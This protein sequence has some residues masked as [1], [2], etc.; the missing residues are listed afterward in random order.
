MMPL[1]GYRMRW[2]ISSSAF[3]RSSSTGTLPAR[4]PLFFEVVVESR[5]EPRE[6]TFFRR[7]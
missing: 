4:T 2:T 1:M 5:G 7:A 3:L 6:T